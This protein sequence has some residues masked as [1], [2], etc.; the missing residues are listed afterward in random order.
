M[1]QDR[2]KLNTRNVL[3]LLEDGYDMLMTYHYPNEEVVEIN[4]EKMK[5]LEWGELVTK[6]E[7]NEKEKEKDEAATEKTEQ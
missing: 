7:E 1:A 6:I 4:Y 2:D 3:V 5:Q